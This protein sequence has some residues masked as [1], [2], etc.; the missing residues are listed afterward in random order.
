MA[1]PKEIATVIYHNG[2][3]ADNPVQGSVYT[4]VN[5]IFIYVSRSIMFTQLIQKINN[6]FPTR[7]TEKFAQLL[8]YVPISFHQVFS[9]NN[10]E[11]QDLF[12]IYTS[13]TQLLSENDSFFY[14]QQTSFDQQNHPSSPFTP[15]SQQPQTLTSNRNE[16]PIANKDPIIRFHEENMD[17][18]SEDE[19]QQFF[20]HI[21]HQSN[22]QS[23]DQSDDEGVGR[24]TTPSS[25]S[26]Q[27]HQ[28]MCLVDLNF[29]HLPHYIDRHHFVQQQHNVQPPTGA[30]EVGMTFDEK[31][32]C[33]RAVN[34]YNIRNHFD[35]KKNLL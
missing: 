28:P 18:F 21:N 20:D 32:Q 11:T 31:A 34:E 29:D 10:L 9:Y 17:D 15:P 19:D 14:A 30:L 26:L 35:C 33:I 4:C 8:C 3:I 6:R 25:P 27:Y 22:D 24:P 16:H 13:Y 23:D 12:D 1:P 7:A 5:P 2:R